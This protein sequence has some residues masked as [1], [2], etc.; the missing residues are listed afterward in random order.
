MIS[1]NDFQ[2]EFDQLVNVLDDYSVERNDI[3][4]LLLAM[5]YSNRYD[6]IPN[7]THLKLVNL[8]CRSSGLIQE[9][10]HKFRYS[11]VNELID[12]IVLKS[13]L[14]ELNPLQFTDIM[15]DLKDKGYAT[16]PTINSND[17]CQEVLNFAN[18]QEY[19]CIANIDSRNIS[20]NS[21][22]LSHLKTNTLAA[23]MVES[24]IHRS[25][26]ISRIIN[27][28]VLLSLAMFYL[29]CPIK[30][31]SVSLWHSYVS[32]DGQAKGD[33]AQKFHFD[34]DEFRW[35]KVFIFLTDVTD[36][37]GP[38]VFI[39]GSH[40]PGIK[41]SQLLSKGYVRI[42]DEDM[43]HFHPI[44]TW[45][46]ITCQSG[47]IV[48]ADTRCWHKGTSVRSGIRSVLQP[49]YAPSNFSKVAL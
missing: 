2:R 32:S 47:T 33:L 31:R 4:E 7:R 30:L 1:N 40:R 20:Y 38:H 49:E 14:I 37:N 35:L 36:Q 22:G 6:F 15:Y 8:F 13:D 17:L 46:Q 25:P 24:C 10:I 21:H 44:N 43:R 34:L 39:P 16:L 3:I 5:S 29:R 26:L 11:P 48:L 18:H 41:S 9:L 28:P 19:T 12:S 27:D 45:Q 42:D 23:S